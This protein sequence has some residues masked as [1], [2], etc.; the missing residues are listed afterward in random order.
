MT[1]LG[2]NSSHDH[3][4]CG[5]RSICSRGKSSRR[6]NRHESRI[7][8]AFFTCAFETHDHHLVT[9]WLYGWAP[10]KICRTTKIKEF[11]SIRGEAGI[12]LT[13]AAQNRYQAV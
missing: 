12:G 4:D 8:V 1:R 10:K 5:S 2:K 7:I 6:W 11:S 13:F 9:S 3:S